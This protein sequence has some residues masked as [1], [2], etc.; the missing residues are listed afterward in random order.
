MIPFRG[1]PGVVNQTVVTFKQL[2]THSLEC[3]EEEIEE[4]LE[5]SASDEEKTKA[6]VT[7]VVLTETCPLAN[8]LKKCMRP[9]GLHGGSPA[10]K[11]LPF[12]KSHILFLEKPQSFV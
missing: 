10:N 11:P 8:T 12:L 3:L 1:I 6:Q 9:L 5:S 4:L 2:F 7:K